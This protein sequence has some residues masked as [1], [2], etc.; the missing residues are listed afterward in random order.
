[1]QTRVL[2][3]WLK[4]GRDDNPEEKGRSFGDLTPILTQSD[5]HLERSLKN[6]NKKIYVK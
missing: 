3:C 2:M 6:W 1:M 5:T 4:V